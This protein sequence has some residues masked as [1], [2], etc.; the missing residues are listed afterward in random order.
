M[1]DIDVP[2]SAVTRY[3]PTVG[4]S[5]DKTT[6]SIKVKNAYV[7]SLEDQFTYGVW[8]KP[9][10]NTHPQ[11]FFLVMHIA[12]NY[13]LSCG[14]GYVQVAFRNEKP[15]WMWKKT[16]IQLN[17]DQWTHIAV[18]YDSIHRQA[19]VMK[20][21]VHSDT[22]Q[23]KGRLQPNVNHLIVKLLRL[24]A[25]KDDEVQNRNNVHLNL[26]SNSEE[27]F[28]GMIAHL[29]IWRSVLSEQQLKS[30][31]TRPLHQPTPEDMQHLLCWWKFDEGY[32]TKVYDYMNNAPEGTI[33]G[34]RWWVAPSA[35]GKVEIPAST[36]QSDLKQMFN[37]PLSSDVQL[38][39]EDYTGTPISAHRALLAARS[40]AF[41]A[42]LLNDMSE[43]TMK[44]ITLKEI[45]FDILTLLIQYFY[46][47]CVTITE[48]N[49]VDL[50]MASDRFQ[51]KRLQAMCEDYMM[52]NIE[53][54]NVCDLFSLA[55]RVHAAQL[56][57]FCMNWIVSN[58]S[59]VFKKGEDIHLPAEL[60]KEIRDIVAPVYFPSPKRRKMTQAAKPG[61][62]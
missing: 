35:T 46:T 57:T 4:L 14:N 54:D 52:K 33:T 21:G 40:E 28:T 1:A 11:E 9:T 45:K 36:L 39:V 22:I 24:S 50:L 6:D 31:I 26:N 56:K 55:D 13:A 59:E 27:S 61:A 18:S 29:K 34:C 8:V 2:G 47:D 41:K 60:Q 43:S 51:I 37:N 17:T 19:F 44:T 15:G 3:E 48:T 12:N 53:L 5:V 25:T 49:V 10:N 30:Q 32:G 7:L 58:W 16:S 62:V 42:M 23:V 20:D 38:T